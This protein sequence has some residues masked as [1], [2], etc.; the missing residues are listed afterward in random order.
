MRLRI[1]LMLT[2]IALISH[3]I[4]S[5][6]AVPTSMTA[7]GR[8]T[9]QSGTPLPAGVKGFLFRIFDS[10][11]GGTQI[12]P[13]GLGESQT[14]TT[15]ENGL[16]TATI[17]AVN[18]IPDSVF[19]DTSRWLEVSVTDLINPAVTFPRTPLLSGPY[20]F[21]V[22]RVQ[23][24][25][26]AAG[27]S[28]T[29]KLSIGPGH[30]NTGADAFVAGANNT[31][32]GDQATVPG[33]HSN[34][35]NGDF[36]MAAG[37]R[38]KANHVGSFVWGDQTDA[39]IATTGPDQFLI[40]A[41]GGVGIGTN[42]PIGL[43]H[44]SSAIPTSGYFT[45]S[46]QDPE[47]YVLRGEYTGPS[48]DARGVLGKSVPEDYW[49]IGGEFIGGFIGAQGT[50]TATGS[51]SYYGIRGIV[52]GGSGTVYGCAGT[53]S[54]G[55]TNYGVY[56]QASG[57]SVNYA[58]YFDGDV[59]VTGTISSGSG[60]SQIDHPL[61]PENKYLNQAYVESP[62]MMTVYNGNITTD[63]AGTAVVTLP[64]YVAA[65]NR[66]FRYQLT[67]IGEF[68]QA[69]IA[70]EIA[71]NQFTIRT[72]KPKVKVSWQVTG[73][74]QDA[75]ANASRIPVQQAKPVGERGLY[76]HPDAYGLPRSTGIE[77]QRQQTIREKLSAS[78]R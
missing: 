65:L 76:K 25:D 26:G 41:N 9:D 40:R 3:S 34:E 78:D 19:A 45:S 57:G 51:N 43:L 74:R 73:V 67:V 47:T 42:L 50:V 2:A 53:A 6:A 12:W 39:D 64:E 33:G 7:Q 20:A 22:N 31:A 63:D 15:D 18:P 75:Y 29:S 8:L 58:G 38:A 54:G 62:E 13:E 70:E 60:A 68:A 56:G 1:T 17:G 49:G 11:I 24:V 23:S 44:V 59:N 32:S 46:F 5:L 69:I 71:D 36:S 72:D 27:G 4:L 66:D 37:R 14:I 61:D 10:E 28:I 77:F 16:W 48:A 30:S 52:R 55:G 21:S 35:A